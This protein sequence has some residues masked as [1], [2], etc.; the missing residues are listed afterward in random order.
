MATEDFKRK[1]TVMA[2]AE[3]EVRP[4]CGSALS[5]PEKRR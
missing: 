4:V 5:K 1:L 2:R 3:D